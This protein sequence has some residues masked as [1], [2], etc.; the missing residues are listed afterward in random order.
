MMLM[1][2]TTTMMMMM[3]MMKCL[4]KKLV[5]SAEVC[6]FQSLSPAYVGGVSRA[7]CMHATC[8]S[9]VIGSVTTTDRAFVT[10]IICFGQDLQS[11]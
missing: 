2:T 4:W 8:G 11:G 9:V 10:I 5:C 3:M 6:S 7:Y 1:M